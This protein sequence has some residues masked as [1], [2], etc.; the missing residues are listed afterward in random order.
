MTTPLAHD[1]VWM[2]L[3]WLRP[4]EMMSC[5]AVCVGWRD[6]VDSVG[7]DE[8]K[9]IYRQRV[10]DWI[11]VS[12]L[13]DWRRASVVASLNVPSVDAL[14]VWNYRRVRIVAPWL[15]CGHD[16]DAPLRE[17]VERVPCLETVDFLYDC[18]IRLRGTPRSCLSRDDRQPC[19]NC[20]GRTRQRCLNPQY[21]Y[22][23]RYTSETLVTDDA[24]GFRLLL[25]D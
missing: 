15:T 22:F 21:E 19:A 16:I 8:W 13:F 6:V 7:R 24:L 11:A 12:P 4:V 17:G 9:A 5:R 10:C 14:C 2:V 23:L 25:T 18:D 20:R 3:R 1:E